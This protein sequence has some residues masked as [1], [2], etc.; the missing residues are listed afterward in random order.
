MLVV[1]HEDDDAALAEGAHEAHRLLLEGHVADAQ[2]L[3]DDEDV[4]IDM[5]A[6][7]KR[8]P[9]IH[10]ARIVAHGPVDEVADAGELLDGR[11]PALDLGA[12]QA[13]ERRA[14]KDILAAGEFRIEARAELQ[15][16]GD[17]PRRLDRS[18]ARLENAADHLEQGR[19][20]GAV[21]ADDADALADPEIEVDIAQRPVLAAP[22][23]AQQRVGK[24]RP[25]RVVEAEAL[26]EAARAHED[27]RRHRR[28][29]GRRRWKKAWPTQNTTSEAAR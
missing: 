12:A 15:E 5:G 27:L 18:L 28:N 13:I 20:A 19:L 1:R 24:P 14:Q 26:A 6:D 7:G 21:A 29:P 17:A 22:L 16:R 8:Q 23:G 4:G 11:H 9:R 10:A 25:G 2:N 3:V